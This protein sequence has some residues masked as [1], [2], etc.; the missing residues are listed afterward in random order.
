MDSSPSDIDHRASGEVE[1]LITIRGMLLAYPGLQRLV[2]TGIQ[3]RPVANIVS[4]GDEPVSGPVSEDAQ[5]PC[6]KGPCH[7]MKRTACSQTAGPT[8]DLGRAAAGA[9]TGRAHHSPAAMRRRC[10][11]NRAC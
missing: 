8:P 1:L 10:S 7:S 11:A 5:Q 4:Q 9:G 3:L 2:R 6:S